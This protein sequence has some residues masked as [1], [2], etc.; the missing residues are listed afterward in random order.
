MVEPAHLH[1]D[2]PHRLQGYGPGQLGLE[3]GRLGLEEMS[4]NN[5]KV[6]DGNQGDQATRGGRRGSGGAGR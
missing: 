4:T 3:E 6:G 5:H 1:C 2:I